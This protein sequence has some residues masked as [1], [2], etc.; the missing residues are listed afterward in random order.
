MSAAGEVFVCDDSDHCVQVFDLNGTFL[1][2]LGSDID[3]SDCYY[4]GIAISP[5]GEVVVTNS[6]KVKVFLADGTF[7]RS[8]CLPSDVGGVPICWPMD[9]S[10]GVAVTPSGDIFVSYFEI[11]VI[12]VQP[13]GS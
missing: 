10:T 9:A 8:L 11:N 7:V 2:F 3:N 4:Q 6:I 13:A 5:V 12:H 1:R